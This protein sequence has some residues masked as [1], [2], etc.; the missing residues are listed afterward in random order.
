M[1]SLGTI[2]PA[3]KVTR[4]AEESLSSQRE[5]VLA[6]D[7][8]VAEMGLLDRASVSSA[9]DT[10]AFLSDQEYRGANSELADSLLDDL[11][12]A[13]PD[14]IWRKFVVLRRRGG[15]LWRREYP[16]TKGNALF[17]IIGD[18]LPMV[19]D[20]TVLQEKIY[21]KNV[22]RFEVTPAGASRVRLTIRSV[23]REGARPTACELNLQVQMRG[24][25]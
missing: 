10:L 4:E 24:G 5:V 20:S 16:Y 23:F 8:L 11:N 13:T 1:L 7:R 17:Q 2:V 14:R 21:T 12:V 9:E 22:E 15:D 18:E 25:N 6:F 3:Y 19:G